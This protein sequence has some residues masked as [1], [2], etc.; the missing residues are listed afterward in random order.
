MVSAGGATVRRCHVDCTVVVPEDVR[1]DACDGE[2]EGVGPG[3]VVVGVGGGEEEALDVCAEVGD[4][5]VEGAIVVAQGWGV[6]ATL[7]VCSVSEIGD[8]GGPI[9]GVTGEF[10]VLQ[11]FTGID[12]EAGV[13]DEGGGGAEGGVVFRDVRACWVGVPAGED[14]VGVGVVRCRRGGCSDPY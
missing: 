1:V 7:L 4:D 10:P 8:L 5:Q 9:E 6:D 14:G 3:G 2:D 12:G 13:G 11:V